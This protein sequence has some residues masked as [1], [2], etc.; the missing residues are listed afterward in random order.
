MEIPVLSKENC[1]HWYLAFISEA[2]GMECVWCAILQQWPLRNAPR[3]NATLY[4]P[5]FMANHWHQW[6]GVISLHITWKQLTPFYGCT[7]LKAYNGMY[8]Q[9]L[10]KQLSMKVNG[11]LGGGGV[12][13]RGGIV[14]QRFGASVTQCSAPACHYMWKYSNSYCTWYLNHSVT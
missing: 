11:V 14:V 9:L 12:V 3:W 4:D 2:T 7:Q 6:S 8:R 13:S 1:T 10:E 5:P